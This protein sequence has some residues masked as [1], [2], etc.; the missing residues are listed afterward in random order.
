MKSKQLKKIKGQR[1]RR[2]SRIRKKI[3]GTAKRPRLAIH[4]SLNNLS[5]QIIDDSAGKTL[6]SVH[7]RE[8]GKKKV[9]PM[10]AAKQLGKKLAE[11]AKKAKIETVVFDRR[12]YK[13]HGRVKEFAEAVRKEGIKF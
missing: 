1:A 3:V 7:Q 8:L 11:K 9:K 12:H 2:V 10:D 6:V 4:R 13:F 5:A